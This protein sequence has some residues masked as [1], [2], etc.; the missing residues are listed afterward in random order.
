MSV[1]P[2]GYLKLTVVRVIFLLLGVFPARN[3]PDHYVAVGAAADNDVAQRSLFLRLVA[4]HGHY[5]ARVPSQRHVGVY[6]HVAVLGGLAALG[7]E[8]RQVP[9][10][11]SAVFRGTYQCIDPLDEVETPDAIH[12]RLERAPSLQ[13]KLVQVALLLLCATTTAG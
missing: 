7:S 2:A 10:L 11:Q 9:Y 4:N 1:V 8:P 3:R 12:M 6:V 5:W 13:L